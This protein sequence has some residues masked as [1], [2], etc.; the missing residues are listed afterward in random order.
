MEIKIT[1]NG[2][3]RTYNGDYDT[4]YNND[5]TEIIQNFIDDARQ[6]EVGN[7]YESGEKEN[8]V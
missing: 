4:L 8:H 2:I 5:W 6:Y 3:E 1:I 7:K